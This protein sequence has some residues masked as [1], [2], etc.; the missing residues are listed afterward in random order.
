VTGSSVDGKFTFAANGTTE[1]QRG[2]RLRVY[3]NSSFVDNKMR[4]QKIM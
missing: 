2:R 4:P 1:F 3:P